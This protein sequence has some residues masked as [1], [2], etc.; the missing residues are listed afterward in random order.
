MLLAYRETPSFYAVGRALGVTH[1]TVERCVRRAEKFGVME[2]LDDSPRPGRERIITEEARTFVV[3]LACRKPK[4]L[5]Y[6]H[7]L[8]T[9]RLLTRHIREHGPAVGHKCLANLAQGTLCKILAAYEIK[10]HKVRYYL[11]R[12]DPL[13]DEK[14]AEVLCVYREVE[15]LKQ[16]AIAQEQETPAVAIISYDEKPGVQ[17]IGTTAPDLPPEPLRHGCV[18]RDHEYVRHGTLSLLAGIDLVTGAVHAT[19]EER[20]RSREFVGFL[21]KLD[22]AYPPSTATAAPR[23]DGLSV[24]AAG[25]CGDDVGQDVPGPAD[26]GGIMT[27]APQLLLAHHLKALKLPTFLREYDKL[28]RQCAAEGLDHTRY[29]LRLA[30]LELIDRERRMV[31]RRIKEARFPAGKSLDSF[32]FVAI[33][34]LNKTLVLELARSEYVTRRENIIAVGNSGT[35]KTH[36]GLGLGLAA[37]QKGLSVGFNTASALVHELLEARDEKRLLRL[38]RQLAG[39]KLLIIDELGYVPLSQTG[40]ELLFEVF[41]QRYERGS[42][43]VTSNLPFDEWTSVFG[44]E[45]LTGALL[46]R[47]THHVHI[48]EMN[49]DSYRLNQSKRRSRR[50]S[51]ETPTDHPTRA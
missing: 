31:E 33:P 19:V 39:Y 34:S 16:S 41:S 36:I 13:F 47:L 17:A 28:A 49:G 9:T 24:S 30:E 12:R 45:R 2:A 23:H 48:L 14:M 37:C 46:D 43:I 29:L 8:W 4:D 7:E 44:S 26:G 11:E 38:Q 42:T 27:D 32:D 18:A 35:G 20:H 10:P 22:A 15:V 3:D 1:Q 5:G 40:A 21:R 25:P 51:P 6:P 50:A